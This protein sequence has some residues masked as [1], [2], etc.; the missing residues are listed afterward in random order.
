MF[1]NQFCPEVLYDV[2]LI[3]IHVAKHQVLKLQLGYYVFST[4]MNHSDSKTNRQ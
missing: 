4:L 3:S 1:C 2:F